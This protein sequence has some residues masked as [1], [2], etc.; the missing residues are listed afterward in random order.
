MLIGLFFN[1]IA[2]AL[3]FLCRNGKGI[4]MSVPEL[5]IQIKNQPG[6]LLKISAILAET[7]INVCAVAASSTGKIGWVRLVVENEKLAQE[8]LE[9]C[10]FKVNVGEAVAVV[11]RDEPGALDNVL[12]ILDD[13][14]INVDYIYNCTS[15]ASDRGIVIIGVQTPGKA[16][17]LLNKEQVETSNSLF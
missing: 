2:P 9:E 4:Q 8:C 3:H 15:V 6:Q 13:G 7:D 11:L 1:G 14:S 10:G 5:S 16:E 17:K 12:K